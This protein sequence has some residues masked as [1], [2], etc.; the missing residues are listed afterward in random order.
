MP[1]D[2]FVPTR[3]GLSPRAKIE[4]W[5]VA[6]GLAVLLALAGLGLALWI[7]LAR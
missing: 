2:P 6:L 4:L 5:H 3:R 1:A 7:D